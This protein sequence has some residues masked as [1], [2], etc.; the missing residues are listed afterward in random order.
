MSAH[1]LPSGLPHHDLPRPATMGIVTETRV[2]APVVVN[3]A[4]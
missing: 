3:S 4:A 2:S 1:L